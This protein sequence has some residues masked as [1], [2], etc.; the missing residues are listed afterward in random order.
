MSVSI[1]IS[2]GEL[3]DKITILEIKARRLIEP[4][5]R[6]KVATE[7]AR[8]DERR[9]EVLRDGPRLTELTRELAEINERLWD[10][11]D[12][13]RAKERDK[14]FDQEFI[15]LARSVYLSNDIRA[16]I[17][18]RIN[19]EFSSGIVEEKQYQHY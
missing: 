4:G 19:E 14:A 8:L 9:R 16:S 12:R 3:I 7:L 6:Q 10:I 15:E 5:R 17:K 11:E 2:Y 13:L 18:H 1:E